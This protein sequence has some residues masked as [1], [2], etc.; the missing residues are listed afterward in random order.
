MWERVKMARIDTELQ[1]RLSMPDRTGIDSSEIVTVIVRYLDSIQG[2]PDRIKS[3]RVVELFGGY[4][5]ITLPLQDVNLLMRFPEIIYIEISKP[6]YYNL[7]TAR[8]ASCI[9]GV[10]GIELQEGAS[11]YNGLTGKGV[12]VGIVDSGIDISHPAFRLETGESRIRFL[13]S[14]EGHLLKNDSDTY[15]TVPAGY[16]FG[17]EY[18]QSE[19]T[20]VL[21][22]EAG[23]VSPAL[24]ER[25]SGH[26][27]AVA[28]IA[29]GNGNGSTGKRYRGIATQSDLI[30]VQLGT[31]ETGYTDIARVMMGVDYVLRKSLALNMPIVINLSFGTN[32]GAHD[33]NT[34]FEQ[35]LTELNGIGKNCIVIAMGNEG[36]SRHHAEFRL[37]HEELS[38]E[39]VVGQN[40]RRLFLQV[41]KEYVDTID[42]RLISPSGKMI[43]LMQGEEETYRYTESLGIIS[44]YGEPTPFQTRQEIFFLWRDVYKVENG[45]W[46]LLAIPKRIVD[47][48]INLWLP[49]REVT[50]N[51]TGFLLPEVNT[52]LT[53]PATARNIISV[54]AYD[55]VNERYADFSGRGNTID[56]RAAPDLVAPGV[57]IITTLPGGRY[58]TVTGTSFAAPFVS[59]CV[60]LMMEWGIVQENDVFLYGEKVKAYLWKGAKQ[61]AGQTQVPD[62]KV[63]WG[64]ICL[65]DSF[66][67]GTR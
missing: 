64:R 59:G 21:E 6:V 28:G 42:F 55:A 13:W 66:P 39:F 22:M 34:L 57:D 54:G 45:V 43:T 51:R 52:T 49:T 24:F 10:Q 44:V 41:W 48:R 27:T 46:Q 9:T 56:G 35:Y 31:D 36:D 29:A 19:L 16:G 18:T 2:I 60:A 26:G 62:T 20:E 67:E 58:G 23:D 14:Q 30:V 15:G 33:G 65:A 1:A 25:T 37:G 63:G 12:L 8:E 17:R 32:Q 7:E 4:G 40:E 5:I 61:F 11:V 38:I 47:G 50:G 3:A 53:I